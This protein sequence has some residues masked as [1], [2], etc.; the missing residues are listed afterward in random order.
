M[1]KRVGV[2]WNS[3]K[4]HGL[5]VARS[6]IELAQGSDMEPVLDAALADALGERGG[7][8]VDQMAAECDAIVVLGGDG[9]ILSAYAVS[10]YRPHGLHDRAYTRGIAGR[11][12]AAARGRVRGGAAHDDMRVVR[13]Y[14]GADRA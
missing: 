9:T 13:R 12:E 14:A 6:V 1:V 10:Q 2:Y 3:G 11:D 8:S 4:T 7:L 5:S